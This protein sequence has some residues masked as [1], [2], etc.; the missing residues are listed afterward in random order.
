MTASARAQLDALDRILAHE[1]VGEEHLELAALVDSVRAG[2]PRMEPAFRERL[3]GEV[4]ARLSRPRRRLPRPTRP[5]LRLAALG[6]GGLVAAAVAFAIVI[7]SGVLGGAG[8]S[9]TRV[10]S[11]A[12]K[13]FSPAVSTPHGALATNGTA[14]P[15][16]GT[17]VPN[18]P[19]DLHAAPAHGSARL[20]RRNSQLVLAAAAA[21]MQRVANE[22][23]TR[24]EQR[25]G[26]V[27]SSNVSVA[28]AGGGAQ[29]SLQ[30]PSPRLGS[31]IGAL[32]SL[33]AVRSLNQATT[34]VTSTYNG[35]DA[36]LAD[37]RA[38]AA[39]LRKELASAP[40]TAQADAIQKKL[41]GVERRIAAEAQ[42]VA[43][44]LGQ[45]RT[46]TLNVSVVPAAAAHHHR[47]GGAGPLADSFN[48]ALHVLVEMLAVALVVLAIA[49]PFALT[50]LAVAWSAAAL[51]Q[52]S[53]ERA[54][55][56]A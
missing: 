36:R 2:A 22:I 35:I 12:L 14:A 27:A 25:G 40:T 46:A 4:A 42:A 53:R 56:A 51:R 20:V 15:T 52:R 31:L 30:I 11:D 8:G 5:R 55:R 33:A 16:A 1:H 34:D 38:L 6:G 32:S 49:L 29:F 21:S 41:N 50:G 47:S 26:V 28:S 19:V 7:S 17:A 44:L 54:I 43:S 13:G 23:V 10:R 24:T 37:H 48:N 9:P 3:D 18:A 45:A 39:S